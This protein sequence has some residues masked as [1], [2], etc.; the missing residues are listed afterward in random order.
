VGYFLSPLTGLRNKA[1]SKVELTL[2]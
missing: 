1:S 2:N